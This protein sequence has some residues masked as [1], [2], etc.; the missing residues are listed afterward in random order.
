MSISAE[1]ETVVSL[2]EKYVYVDTKQ[3]VINLELHGNDYDGDI[4]GVKK[5]SS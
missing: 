5:I 2:I 3:N 4:P 1:K